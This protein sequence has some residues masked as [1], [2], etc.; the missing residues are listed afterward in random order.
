MRGEVISREGGNFH[1]GLHHF[2]GLSRRGLPSQ[3]P[4][5]VS[6]APAH[7]RSSVSMFVEEHHRLCEPARSGNCG[8]KRCGDP[9]LHRSEKP[10]VVEGLLR[11]AKRCVGSI[12][13]PAMPVESS[14]WAITLRWR[15]VRIALKF[16]AGGIEGRLQLNPAPR[17]KSPCSS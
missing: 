16:L 3:G 15:S 14:F 2:V 4:P 1:A 11:R 8:T 10:R 5:S 6:L 12:E 9:A 7:R 17:R 13:C